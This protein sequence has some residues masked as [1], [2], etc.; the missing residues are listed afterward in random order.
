MAADFVARP[1]S[2]ILAQAPPAALAAKAA[3]TRIPIVFV[4][5]L[6]P[7]AAGLVQSLNHPG[8]N[9]TGMTL[10]SNVLGQKRLELLRDI[11]PKTSRVAL[12][13]NPIS[14]DTP[15]EIDSVQAGAKALGLQ[16]AIVNASTPSEIDT[17]FDKIAEQRPDGLL[18]GTDPFFLNPRG[19]DC[20]GGARG[21]SGDLSVSRLCRRRRLPQL[22]DR[23]RR[24]VPPS[25]DLRRSDTEGCQSLRPSG[26]ATHE[27]RA[28]H[29]FEGG[30]GAWARYSTGR[31]GSFG[32]GD[33]VVIPLGARAAFALH[34][35]DAAAGRRSM[36]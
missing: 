24:F 11:S 8:G 32:R 15:G 35:H 28:G 34:N 26:H 33:R 4:V 2:L 10:I 21:D 17:A 13:V 31:A 23:Y 19:G 14:P 27:I 29:Q 7:V 6:D 25:R 9:A 5:G 22:R 16:L 36:T 30:G 3:T 20:P 18:V 12:L 1:V